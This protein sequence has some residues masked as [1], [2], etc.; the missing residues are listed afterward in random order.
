MPEGFVNGSGESRVSNTTN[1]TIPGVEAETL[2]IRLSEAGLAASSGSACLTG[3]L[4]P[5]HVLEAMGLPRELAFSSLRFSLGRYTTSEEIDKV[6][7][8]VPRLV[9]ELRELSRVGK[10]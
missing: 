5:S 1:I 8:I 9:R 3:A 6:L 2:L 7:Q 10:S 4:E